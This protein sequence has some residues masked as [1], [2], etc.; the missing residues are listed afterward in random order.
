ME[1]E[2]GNSQ[3]DF[4]GSEFSRLEFGFWELEFI[5]NLGFVICDFLP[6]F[7]IFSVVPAGTFFPVGI[8]FPPINRCAIFI[9]PCG[10]SQHTVS[11]D[12]PEKHFP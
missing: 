11:R 6:G 4:R 12:F 9:H 8:L 7:C 5:W 1:V 2:T 3:P 10:I